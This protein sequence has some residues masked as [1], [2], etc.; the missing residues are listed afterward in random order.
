MDASVLSG[1]LAAQARLEDVN[2]YLGDPYPIYAR[3]R[4]EAPVYWCETGNFWALTKYEDIAFIS[5]S[6]E[7]VSDQQRLRLTHIEAIEI[8]QRARQRSSQP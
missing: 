5:R 7:L 8:G 3:L 4:Q 6:P 1:E 2:F